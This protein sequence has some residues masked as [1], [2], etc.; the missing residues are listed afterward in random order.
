M[1]VSPVADVADGLTSKARWHP[2]PPLAASRKSVASCGGGR[3]LVVLGGVDAGLGR[4][5]AL[6][7]RSSASYQIR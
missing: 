1:T 7:D 3:E 6:Y 4:I 5:A 2:L